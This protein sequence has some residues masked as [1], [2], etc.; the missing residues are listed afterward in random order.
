MNAEPLFTCPR[1]RRANF[2]ARGLKAHVCRPER[3]NP[4]SMPK[5]NSSEKTKTALVVLNDDGARLEK[6]ELA[7][8]QTHIAKQI[9]LIFTTERENV[10]RRIFV[11]LA[12]WRIKASLKHGEFGPWLKKHVA[13]GH[14]HINH[15]MRAAQSFVET[16]R[17]GKL[18]VLALSSGEALATKDA[19]SKRVMAAA[20]KFV[21]DLSWCELLDK[22]GIKDA[23]KTGGART[24]QKSDS[25]T[26]NE[27]Q[28][29]LFA[30][31][32][33]GGVITQ[34]E[35]LLVKENRL[36]YLAGHPEE[37]RGVVESLRKL[38]DQ[39]EAAAKPILEK[40]SA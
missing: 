6:Q 38:A 16:A 9:D 4:S 35:T 40:T 31:D 5:G 7:K 17:L 19:A 22:H 13:A 12:L 33:I 37:V 28:L 26:P 14:S 15:M 18:E 27:E 10:M 25:A 8:F 30:R 36:Q 23:A 20:E 39:V 29:Y 3:D 2:T 24:A 11:G 32:E 1:C 21:G 34:A